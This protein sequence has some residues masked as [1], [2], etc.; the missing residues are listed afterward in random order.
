VAR[1]AGSTATAEKPRGAIKTPPVTAAYEVEVPPLLE[2]CEICGTTKNLEQH[3]IIY[4]SRGGGD[5]RENIMTLCDR[6]HGN[7]SQERWHLEYVEPEAGDLIDLPQWLVIDPS[8]PEEQRVIS[9]WY[10][11]W[12]G[13]LDVLN[14]ALGQHASIAGPLQVK[15]VAALR[16]DDLKAVDQNLVEHEG[17]SHVVRAAFY[18]Y[19]RQ[20]STYGEGWAEGVAKFFSVS[21]SLVYARARMFEILFLPH[22]ERME[23][24]PLPVSYLEV[25]AQAADPE[26]ALQLAITNFEKGGYSLAQLKADL[27]LDQAPSSEGGEEVSFTAHAIRWVLC[28][29]CDHQQ[30][31]DLNVLKRQGSD[32]YPDKPVAEAAGL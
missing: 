28:P 30:R 8:L 20:R 2:Y 15:A 11:P 14:T 18:F 27:G 24:P 13:S 21:R 10:Q 7:V 31:V 32:P 6:C 29:H 3:H 19:C 26:A 16:W 17:W 25:V 9:R 1:N 22:A 12:S 4:R 5:E 23:H